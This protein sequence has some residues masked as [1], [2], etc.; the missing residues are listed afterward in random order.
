MIDQL[1]HAQMYFFDM[2][3]T[4]GILKHLSGN[5]RCIDEKLP[6]VLN[7]ILI[8]S[9]QKKKMPLFEYFYGIMSD[10][11]VDVRF[12]PSSSTRR[13]YYSGRLQSS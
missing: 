3:L 1:A 4:G 8:T 2:T 7:K 5:I 11:N 10:R 6:Q 9:K 13:F 12:W